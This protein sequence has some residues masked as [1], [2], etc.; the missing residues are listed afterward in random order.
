[1]PSKEKKQKN[2]D[3]QSRPPV[4]V[5]LGHVDHGKSSLLE[6][7]KDLKITE[8]EAGGITQH[9]GAYVVSHKDKDVTF[10]D[11][12]GHE[13]FFAMRSRGTKLADIGIL[14]V[15]ADES[16]KEQTKE[17]INHLKEAGMPFLV[18]IN[19]ID[20][21]NI[22]IE[23]VKQDLSK[24]DVFVESYGGGVPSVNVSA[25]EK[26][27]IDDLLEM[28]LLLAEM[29]EMTSEEV[30]NAQGVVVEARRD[31][32]K[33]IIATF[34]VKE[35]ILRK[36]DVV[37]TN[38]SYGKIRTMENFLGEELSEAGP[39]VPVQIMGPRGCPNAGEEFFVFQKLEEAKKFAEKGETVK[40]EELSSN[41]EKTLN[42][43]LKAD[44]TGSLEAIE[45][46][47]SKIP[48]E[49]VEIKIGKSGIG[50]VTESDIEYAKTMGAN[51]FT[52]RVKIDKTTQK[53]AL[54]EN[55]KIKS[56]DI[57]YELIDVV[58]EMAQEMLGE[59]TV[60]TETGKIKIL[61]VFRT[62][63]ERQI[64]GGRVIKG[65]A[66]KGG[67][68]EI[69][70]GEE[71]VAGGKIINIKKEEKDVERILENEEFGMLIESKEKIEEGDVIVLYKE[72]KIKRTL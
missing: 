32:Q 23:K 36:G 69:W 45:S 40:E 66:R 52:F 18:A 29:E 44:V 50:N 25:K 24:E 2:S 27:G 19:K 28:V 49:E 72:E 3:L 56:F 34:L 64:L 6:A 8:K 63:K 35:G 26:T 14:V 5:V 41:S 60:K 9:I 67:V 16:I 38:C 58:R 68:A 15:A 51:I 11:T 65:E 33:G 43:I 4:V 30:D 31:A 47:L 42:I 10:I 1:M 22:D 39:S 57:I 20:K 12:P 46:S 17:A 37:A 53:T 54:R 7:I 13:A 59:E 21:K 70:R 48:Q 61:A 62:Q 71:K 55:V